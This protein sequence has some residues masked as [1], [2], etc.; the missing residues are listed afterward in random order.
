MASK[1][2]SYDATT[3]GLSGLS[4]HKH[5]DGYL[6]CRYHG[7]WWLVHRL[8]F[9]L[10]GEELPPEVDHINHDKTDNRWSNLRPADSS[11]NMRNRP[12]FKNNTSGVTGVSWHKLSQKWVAQ[13]NVDGKRKHI[14]LD[15]TL[16]DAV[17]ARMRAEKEYDYHPNHGGEAVA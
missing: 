15:D 4:V 7:K 14:G 16:L 2:V 1:V 6:Q 17:A 11:I 3:G 5:P 9:L 8:A 10:M 13:I 12:K